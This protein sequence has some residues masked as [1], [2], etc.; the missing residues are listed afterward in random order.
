[1]ENQNEQYFSTE[2]SLF[3][4]ELDLVSKNL[5]NSIYLRRKYFNE[6]NMHLLINAFEA[7]TILKRVRFYNC[8]LD[9]EKAQVIFSCFK[10]NNNMEII[11]ITHNNIKNESLSVL[12]N[13]IQEMPKLKKLILYKNLIDDK[14]LDYI[15]EILLKAKK[16]SELNLA[17]NKFSEQGLIDYLF[18]SLAQSK[19]LELLDLSNNYISPQAVK[20]LTSS[21]IAGRN[22]TCLKILNLARCQLNDEC[23]I[24]L[25]QLLKAN[26]K[27]KDLN[28]SENKISSKGLYYIS[29]GIKHNSHIESVNFEFNTK[30]GD[31]GI[32][33]YTQALKFNRSIKDFLVKNI[34]YGNNSF[35]SISSCISFASCNI[36]NFQLSH[37]YITQKGMESICAGLRENKKIK[38]ISFDYCGLDDTRVGKLFRTLIDNQNSSIYYIGLEGNFIG[39][40][41]AYWL[42]EL[43]SRN[44]NIKNLFLKACKINDETAKSLFKILN[45]QSVIISLDISNNFITDNSMEELGRSLRENVTL[46]YFHLSGNLLTDLGVNHIIKNLKEN[47]KFEIKV[48]SINEMNISANIEYELEELINDR[49]DQIDFD[50]IVDKQLIKVKLYK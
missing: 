43:V 50:E 9:D 49:K 47:K 40:E 7:S 16:L 12:A 39:G 5:S 22:K 19:S 25:G 3:L 11:D 23:C 32:F 44:K 34:L 21:L 13:D 15:A 35:Y 41:S 14:G 8:S 31:I 37:N 38:T 20:A 17:H 46:N 33:Y 24:Y 29:E 42:N 30:I 36:L 4:N 28:I 10:K 48:L 6:H 2:D 26:L 1:M 27:I 18:N 45:K